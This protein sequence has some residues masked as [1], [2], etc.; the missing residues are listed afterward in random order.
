MAKQSVGIPLPVFGHLATDPVV[1]LYRQIYERIRSPILAGSLAPGTR[2][3][4][5]RTLA[6][7]IGVSR[8]TVELAFS[9][10]EAEGFLIRRVGAG[11]YVTSAIPERDRAPRITAPRA[12]RPPAT[13]RPATAGRD[14]LSARGRVVVTAAQVAEPGAGPMT[15]EPPCRLFA[16]CLPSLESFPLP[17]WRR[18]VARHSRLWQGESLFLGDRAGYRPLR[19]ALA[20]YLAT[21]RGVRCDWRQIIILTSTQQA[22]DLAARLLLDAGDPVWL[23]EPGYL[24]ARAAL[25]SAGARLVPVPV[26]TDGLTV[27]AGIATEPEARLVYLTPSHQYPTGVTMSLARRLALLEWATRTGAWVIEDDYDSEFRYTGRP[28][29]AMQGLDRGERVIYTGT[30]NKVLFPGLRLAYV[31]VPHSL[32][33]AFAAAR[34]IIDGHSPSF[35]QAVLADFIVAGYLSSHIRRM[36]ALY[37]ERRDV[38]L[39]AIA[40]RLAGR[41]EVTASDTGLHAAGWLRR[42]VDDREVSRRSAA[43]GL[44]LPPLSRYYL[45]RRPPPGLLFNYATV[46]PDDL[47]GGI[48]TLATV[49]DSPR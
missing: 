3:P 18:L 42:D 10:L 12:A 33:D 22:L 6:G 26:D 25:E 1:T 30:F 4:S 14:S 29:A 34:T 41:I 13:P 2:L 48:D 44:D 31:V 5:S 37:Q 43:K 27:Q 9:Q 20:T 35:M 47:R 46:P 7:D 36:R 49:L 15:D 28:L 39:D 16:P 19:Q 8:S 11:T 24:G 40:R 21:A 17:I 45:G 32:V 38:L 23:E